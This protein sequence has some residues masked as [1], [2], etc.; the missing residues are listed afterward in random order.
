M[1]FYDSTIPTYAPVGHSKIFH[2]QKDHQLIQLLYIRT[3]TSTNRQSQHP[4]SED[5]GERLRK[6]GPNRSQ[7]SIPEKLESRMQQV[8]I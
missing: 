1:T 3:Y 2:G 7:Q 5:E 6:H 8:T 4:T